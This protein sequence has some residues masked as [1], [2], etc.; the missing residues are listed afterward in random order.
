MIL[1]KKDIDR[2]E[3]GALVARSAT[4]TWFQ[5]PEAYEFFA[6]MPDLYRPF[7]YVYHNNG[8]Q[9]YGTRG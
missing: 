7:I 6:S 1:C 2:A 4:G 3:W 8:G 5:R 9:S